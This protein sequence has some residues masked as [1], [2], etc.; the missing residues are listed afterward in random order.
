MTIDF[1]SLNV[2]QKF[3]S[4]IPWFSTKIGNYSIIVQ[5]AEKGKKAGELSPQELKDE[6]IDG[7]IE[8]YLPEFYPFLY[9][10]GQEKGGYGDTYQTIRSSI[11]NNLEYVKKDPESSF[12][13]YLFS[14]APGNLNFK[15]IRLGL[16]THGL[17]DEQKEK[18]L[19]EA[20]GGGLK[21]EDCPDDDPREQL[22]SY[23][24]GMPSYAAA[25]SFFND[26][27]KIKGGGLTVN[28]ALGDILQTSMAVSAVLND[29]DSQIK[30]FPFPLRLPLDLAS[31]Q[32][33]IKAYMSA[34]SNHTRRDMNLSGLE[35]SPFG[36]DDVLILD[37]DSR[38]RIKGAAYQV[39]MGKDLVEEPLKIGLFSLIKYNASSSDRWFMRTFAEHRRIIRN[40]KS[41]TA[42]GPGLPS[43]IKFI[44]QTYGKLLDDPSANPNAGKSSLDFSGPPMPGISP[45][46]FNK[47]FATPGASTPMDPA[48]AG[49]SMAG[50]ISTFMTAK[51]VGQIQSALEDPDVLTRLYAKS[52][53]KQY[54]TKLDLDK[55][56]ELI[57]DL[58][59]SAQG[60]SGTAAEKAQI[61]S[62][63]E[64][65]EIRLTRAENKNDM[66]GITYW[67]SKL[68]QAESRLN[69]AKSKGGP[70]PKKTAEEILNQILALFG[71]PELIAEALMCLTMGMSFS[72]ERINFA[73]DFGLS[74]AE[75]IEDYQRPK[76]P[77]PMLQMPEFPPLKIGFNIMGD[78][79]LSV[80]I[81]NIILQALIEL[82]FDIIKGLA[83]MIKHNCNNLLNR[84]EQQGAV[85]AG[86]AM[87]NNLRDSNGN[88]TPIQTPDMQRLLDDAFAK[89]GLN[90]DEGFDYLSDLSDGLTP[91]EICQLYNS[92]VDVPDP[93]IQKI[94]LSNK[95]S[96]NPK[97]REMQ[98]RN[99]ILAFFAN[100]SPLCDI[101]SVCNQ[102]LADVDM[103][104]AI[105]NYCLKE[106]DLGSLA[107]QE[108]MQKLADYLN[109][110]IPV[111]MPPIDLLCPD[112]DKFV[113]NPM[114]SRVIPRIFNTLTDNVKMQFVNS[115]E[116]SRT[117][118]LEPKVMAGGPEGGGA[119]GIFK[120][121][122]EVCV[123]GKAGDEC[124]KPP[125]IDHT[126]V[127]LVA[128][129]FEQLQAPGFTIN[130]D[131]CPDLNLDKLGVTADQFVAALPK[132]SLIL[133]ASLEASSADISNL[134]NTMNEIEDGLKKQGA[135]ATPY[136]SYVF[137]TRFYNNFVAQ[138]KQSPPEY[139]DVA[140]SA[141]PD[142][143]WLTKTQ[144]P[145]GKT[146]Y[147]SKMLKDATTDEYGYLRM[148]YRFLT[149]GA[150][151][152]H[153]KISFYS[154][155]DIESGR[156]PALRLR[157][158]DKLLPGV[159]ERWLTG[160]VP[161]ASFSP[162][163][164]S[165]GSPESYLGG[166]GTE[167]D[168]NP[169]IF[170]FTFPL[171]QQLFS[172]APTTGN[173]RLLS[174]DK[175]YLQN[176]LQKQIFPTAFN[177]IIQRTFDYIVRN[178]IFNMVKLNKLNLFKDNTNC[179]PGQQGDL[180]D[181]GGLLH[182]AKE[183]F[184]QSSCNDTGTP[185]DL[186]SD[187]LKLALI[188]L[189]IQVYL[190]EF[191]IK[192][193]FVV[194]AFQFDEIMNKP[195]FRDLLV[196][197]LVS[198]IETK[199]T[200]SR[201][202]LKDFIYGHFEILLQ[203]RPSIEAGG[204]T[205][206]YAPGEVVPFLT[207]GTNVKKVEFKKLLQY[208]VEERMGYT[209]QVCGKMVNTMQSI[210]NIL[211]PAG[212]DKSFE[213]A[214]ITDIL[215]VYKAPYGLRNAPMKSED[216]RV[217][218]AKYAYW[219][220]ISNWSDLAD[221]EVQVP[222]TLKAL[223][224]QQNTTERA[225]AMLDAVGQGILA[226]EQ[227]DW[228]VANLTRPQSVQTIFGNAGPGAMPVGTSTAVD[229]IDIIN[230]TDGA[231][232]IFEGL[233][234]GYKLIF[235]FPASRDATLREGG[236]D[237][238]NSEF[239]QSFSRSRVKKLM[240]DAMELQGRANHREAIL[241]SAQTD[242]NPG[243]PPGAQILG[244]LLTVDI[245]PLGDFDPNVLS[246]DLHAGL[247][248]LLRDD[249]ADT[250]FRDMGTTDQTFKN[251]K[252]FNRRGVEV[253]LPRIKENPEY[254]RFIH[255]TF[256]PE[257][258]MMTPILYNLG[259]TS[260]FFPG[261]E[262]DFE[263][264]KKTIL[265]LFNKISRTDRAPALIDPDEGNAAALAFGLGSGGGSDMDNFGREYILKALMMTPI[266]ILKGIVELVDPHVA[267]SKIIRDI[268]G[269]IFL[270]ISGALD[271]ALTIAAA[272][273]PE[274]DP[275]KA[276]LDALSGEDLLALGFCG[277]NTINEAASGKIDVEGPNLPPL[278][279]R[280]SLN[281]VD[282]TGT[283]AGLF[284][285]PPSIFGIIYILLMLLDQ[286]LGGDAQVESEGPG[287]PN[288]PKNVADS[289][290]EGSNVC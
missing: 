276:L 225:T 268:T 282:F 289:G 196:T 29:Y 202:D 41:F 219:D 36:G 249:V 7:F 156:R 237:Q 177:G 279:P 223:N 160:E 176:K 151:M 274:G 64:L 30:K 269:M 105:E 98:S 280:L 74:I 97:I 188:N 83:E 123:R 78:P 191:L 19:E 138:A 233:K 207:V 242:L 4:Y 33:E 76:I 91:F 205:H 285:I 162:L 136:V 190:V 110:G 144:S 174:A 154:N 67:E 258:V 79:P 179:E 167:S 27:Q 226:H 127:K 40:S 116:A 255:Q 209:Y 102:F 131:V 93:T 252:R 175:K 111:E 206:S 45:A 288:L 142:D 18:I 126:F 165:T 103:V 182:Q 214:F 20:F 65:A 104:A 200:S 42:N 208:L 88:I 80:Q 108:S 273:V 170:N 25:R 77:R 284:M 203:R 185:K 14:S 244:E 224:A 54:S 145:A 94:R 137:P 236:W 26:Q 106:G 173:S 267:I 37:L 95:Q 53:S 71:I 290:G 135:D 277:I 240:I 263:T 68:S 264:T 35:V 22:P 184:K 28:I 24:S 220:R 189:L 86:D 44:E 146:T 199:L 178:G 222:W 229:F 140:G 198:E 271:S 262:R 96:S 12:P 113:P 117:T 260:Q 230:L 39:D 109:N 128:H 238:S 129:I 251:V 32:A 121:L 201:N 216:G 193:I 164:S 217:F 118:L 275:E 272:A 133:R 55:L 270:A 235:N 9:D 132:L 82:V 16:L 204:I 62:D 159:G 221:S 52:S 34:L 266:K 283:L 100:M 254:I 5:P 245:H 6:A 166:M 257:I 250:A 163:F 227:P 210:N 120:A 241:D 2:F 51:E 57:L 85:D 228:I 13:K 23:D 157:C 130:P 84:P 114:V 180:L 278:G 195:L 31:I 211:A 87:K 253:Y 81:R 72:L 8:F 43:V 47:I 181:I 150:D 59:K 148:S 61:E 155:N 152:E 168:F 265:G 99:Q 161:D 46:S 92:P 38:D 10:E 125:K 17:A 212:A 124:V 122:D 183:N 213:D 231:L 232:P 119:A 246:D 60:I 243:H 192:N 141:K 186:A 107:D 115:V 89:Y 75:F 218:F 149:R 69:K 21:A 153:I 248:G 197:S 112:S 63:I 187:A 56:M 261:I 147:F 1:D 3:A 281:G 58:I 234:V 169:Y 70:T 143:V 239:I 139:V 11:S 287:A 66:A 247:Q 101:N 171:Q 286:G 15:K 194:S 90:Q 49:L 172:L 134:A 259:L 48:K 50:K 73:F 158:P 215:G 256:N